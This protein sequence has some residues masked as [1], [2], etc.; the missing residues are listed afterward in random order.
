MAQAGYSFAE[1]PSKSR[2]DSCEA[3]HPHWILGVTMV[4]GSS[5]KTLSFSPKSFHL[6]RSVLPFSCQA[7]AVSSCLEYGVT[8][9]N[10]SPTPGLSRIQQ[11]GK[12]NSALTSSNTVT[13]FAFFPLTHHTSDSETCCS[14][15]NSCLCCPVQALAV[16]SC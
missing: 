15:G 1:F 5:G 13:P 14:Y 3:P 10:R 2:G 12:R 6:L 9:F 11:F 16:T 8:D 4:V 7:G